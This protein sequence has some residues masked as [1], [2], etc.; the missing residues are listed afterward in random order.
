RGW[1]LDPTAEPTQ[2]A[3]ELQARR[4]VVEAAV[5]VRHVD[6]DQ[7][8]CA[9][10]LRRANDDSHRDL[11]RFAELA[12]EKAPVDLAELE[13]AHVELRKRRLNLAGLRR[14]IGRRNGTVADD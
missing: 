6:V 1:Y 2:L 10:E 5:Y 3:H 4:T 12:G 8:V 13:I 11:A 9:L 14:H 7:T